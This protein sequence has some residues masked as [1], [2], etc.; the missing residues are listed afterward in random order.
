MW[1][2]HVTPKHQRDAT[3]STEIQPPYITIM[4]GRKTLKTRTCPH[5]K[6]DIKARGYASHEKSCHN[7]QVK[8][9]EDEVFHCSRESQSSVAERIPP[10]ET[11]PV[12]LSYILKPYGIYLP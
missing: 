4:Y 9:R 6:V 1:C 12:M 7:K 2:H 5:C 11:P 10:G 3:K 8:Q